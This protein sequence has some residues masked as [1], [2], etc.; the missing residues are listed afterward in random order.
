MVVPRNFDVKLLEVLA[1]PENLTPVRLARRSEID[2]VNRRISAGN[3][4][5]WGGAP[6]TTSIDALL[7]RED[8]RIGY[9]VRNGLPVMLID[10]ALVLDAAVG[11]PDPKRSRS[12]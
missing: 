5:R 4:R 7:V 8:N 1:C 12:R 10:Q 11:Q 9:E 2:G 3:Q 6:V